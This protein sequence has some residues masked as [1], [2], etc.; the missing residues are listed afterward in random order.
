[1]AEE[2][3]TNLV[4]TR[5]QMAITRAQVLTIGLS[6]LRGSDNGARSTIVGR[7]AG[8]R[9]RWAK[10]WTPTSDNSTNLELMQRVIR[11]VPVSAGS[12]EVSQVSPCPAPVCAGL[13]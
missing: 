2:A 6:G 3:A 11:Q 8:A 13:Q 12:I 4:I 7:V 1:M 5:D 9:T 10:G